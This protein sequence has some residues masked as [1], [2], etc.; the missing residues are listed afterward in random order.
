MCCLTI[1][2]FMLVSTTFLCAQGPCT[3]T[4]VKEG[5]L[6]MAEDAFSYVPPF[7]QACHCVKVANAT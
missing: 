4:A 1:L 6:P 3:E 2:V 7:W 5:E